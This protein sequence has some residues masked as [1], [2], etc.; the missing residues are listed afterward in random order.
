MTQT[1]IPA[2]APLAG[3]DALLCDLDGVIYAGPAAI[4]GAVEAIAAAQA[5]G[6]AV[7]FV[8]NNASRPVEAVA[9]HLRSLGVDTDA[10]HVFGSAKAGARLAA[11]DAQERGVSAPT[12]MVIGAATLREEVLAAGFSLVEVSSEAQPDYVIQGFD[13]GL[14]WSDLAAAAFAIQRGARW[15]ATNTD[16]TIP[17]AEGIAPGNGSLVAAV[18]NA[19]DIEPL[20][21]GK[22]EPALMLLAAAS[23][24]AKRPMMVGDRL[25]TDVAGGNAAGFTSALVLTGVHTSADAAAAPEA[26]RPDVVVPSL[27]ELL[28]APALTTAGHGA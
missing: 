8:T 11:A 1:A 16:S 21:A 20:V 22:P 10:E 5:A 12:A 25:D 18:R 9:E 17:R 23:L 26:Q 15:V 6:I 28:T 14:G 2:G 19:V 24:G 27:A 3:H 4:P 7:G 13:P